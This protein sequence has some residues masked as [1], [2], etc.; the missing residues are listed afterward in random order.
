MTEDRS[1]ASEKALSPTVKIVRPILAVTMTLGSLAW[2]GD[3]YRTAGLILYTEQFMSA[4]LALAICL[5][6]LHFPARRGETRTNLPWYDGLLAVLGL[7]NG[8]YVAIVYPDLIDRLIGTAPDAIFISVIFF[9]LCLEGL[10]RSSGWTLVIV[11]TIFFVYALTGHLVPGKFE[12]RENHLDTLLIYLSL[13]TSALFGI[14]TNV[15]TTIVFSFVFFGQLLL[16]SGGSEF[17]NDLAMAIMGRYRGGSAKI[18]ITASSLFGSISGLAAS[19]ILATGVVTIPMMRRSGYQR[20]VAAAIEAVASTGGQLMPPVMGAVA[21][22]MAD[23]LGISYGDVVLA[24]TIPAILYY[25]ALFL[26]AD[27]EAAKLRITG[28]DAEHI[29]NILMVI[30]NGWMF[31]IPFAVLIYALFG[32]NLQ[33]ETAALYGSFAVMAVGLVF[34]YGSTRMKFRDI[35]TSLIVTGTSVLDVIMIVAAAGFILGV[36][37][38]SGL[39]FVLTS[40]LVDLG[41]GNLIALLVTAGMICI[42]LGMGLPTVGVYILLAV[43]IAPSLIEVG[44]DPL[45]AHMFIFYLGMMSMITP[46]VAIAAFFAA[47]LAEAPPM[48]TG[49]SAM[50]FGW[51]AYIVPFLFVFSPSLLFRGGYG[52]MVASFATAVGGVWLVSAGL[53]GYFKRELTIAARL[54]FALAGLLLLMP[55]NAV[56]WGHWSDIAG[57]VLG[58]GL[59]VWEIK[60]AR[61]DPAFE[62]STPGPRRL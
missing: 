16:R 7:T 3:L 62:A 12:I 29:P 38:L 47:N 40:V 49:F 30:R 50:R 10:R 53:T 21:F 4:M 42:V 34:G 46:P 20:H 43:T 11:V 59:V 31:T 17:F 27:L 13:D 22:L 14:A 1:H 55:R 33:P 9:V 35:V 51:T 28:I 57:V 23:I 2:A 60:Q 52:E 24:A 5:V 39:G 6:Y 25:V 61:G 56:E 15:V 36:L 18:A 54:A 41:E 32:L 45:A 26:L 37:N 8:A 19:N 58:V 48:R 44:V